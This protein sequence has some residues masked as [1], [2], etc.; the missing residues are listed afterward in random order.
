MTLWETLLA[1]GTLLIIVDPIALAPVF[2][3]LT[4]GMAPDAMRRVALRATLLGFV[5]IALAGLL[6]H[7]VIPMVQAHEG[8]L[9]L[10]LAAALLIVGVAMVTG[11]S[12]MGASASAGPR[13]DPTLVPLT[14]PLIAGPGAFGAMAMLAGRHAGQWEALTTLYA[15]LALVAG[16]TYAAF[17]GAGLIDRRLGARGA[18][19][20]SRL[21]GVV[22][23]VMAAVFL[24]DGLRAFG[25]IGGG[26]GA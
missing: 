17:R 26:S 9:H 23:I 3:A 22:L 8:V 11:R 25:L 15:C 4:A 6:G 12:G 19:A 18:A 7:L 1:F 2:A 24:R 10:A 13:R 14:V 20:I 5:L 21:L 16:L